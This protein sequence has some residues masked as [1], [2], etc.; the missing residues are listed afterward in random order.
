LRLTLQPCDEDEEKDKFFPF[1]YVLEQQWNEIDGK[2]KVLA[3]KPVPVPLFPPH[4]LH[5]PT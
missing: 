2:T 4:I 3:E 1:F 5:G